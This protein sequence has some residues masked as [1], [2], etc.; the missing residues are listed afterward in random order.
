VA[1]VQPSDETTGLVATVTTK[2][3]EI[4][5]TDDSQAAMAFMADDFAASVSV[6]EWKAVRQS[7]NDAVGSTPEYVPHALTWY[8]RERLLAAVDFSGAGSKPATF[9]CGFILWEL[10]KSNQIGFI[11]L[12]ENVVVRDAFRKMPVQQAVQL[13]T[14]FHCPVPLIESVLDVTIQ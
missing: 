6:A 9:V 10:P 2:L 3:F 5:P 12:E 4:L 1:Q 11:R 7:I 8:Q 14:D 13:M